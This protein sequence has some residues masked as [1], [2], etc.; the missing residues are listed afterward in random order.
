MNLVSIWEQLT[1]K[2]NGWQL[3]DEVENKDKLSQLQNEMESRDHIIIGRAG[4]AGTHVAGR[5]KRA[6][7]EWV[8]GVRYSALVG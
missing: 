1:D 4:A 8:S 2:G 7:S 6:V 5:R 3:S